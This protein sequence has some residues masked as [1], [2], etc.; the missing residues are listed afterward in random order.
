MSLREAQSLSDARLRLAVGIGQP[1]RTHA[2]LCQSGR[3]IVLARHR[4]QCALDTIP[5]LGVQPPRV[6][7]TGRLPRLADHVGR[8]LR[9]GT[10]EQVIG[11]DASGRVAPVTDQLAR[12]DGAARHDERDAMRSGV[13]APL[14]ADAEL[15]VAVLADPPSPQPAVTRFVDLRREARCCSGVEVHVTSIPRHLRQI[16]T[17]RGV[18]TNTSRNDLDPAT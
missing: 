3:G 10:D 7:F 5:A 17:V 16:Y 1:K 11:P 15:A 9:R 2:I 12:L 8:V 4:P 18:W 14:S 6:S 13:G